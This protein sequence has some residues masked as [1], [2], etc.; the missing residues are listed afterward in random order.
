MW[1]D[2]APFADEQEIPALIGAAPFRFERLVLSRSLRKS[3]AISSAAIVSQL[4]SNACSEYS[5]VHLSAEQHSLNQRESRQELTIDLQTGLSQ[6]ERMVN[7][8]RPLLSVS[9]QQHSALLTWLSIMTIKP[10]SVHA[11][12][13]SS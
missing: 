9:L 4:R 11:L 1:H 8:R 2:V 10:A 13:I 6:H 7:G 3:A 5:L 12:R